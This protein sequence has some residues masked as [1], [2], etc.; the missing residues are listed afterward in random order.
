MLLTDMPYGCTDCEWDVPVDLVAYWPLAKATTKN[1]AAHCHFCQ[2][3]FAARLWQSN[4]KEFRYDLVYQKLNNAK[5]IEFNGNIIP[6]AA[7]ACSQFSVDM[8]PNTMTPEL[9]LKY[10]GIPPREEYKAQE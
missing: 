8:P 2:M 10:L 7:N 3:P 6:Y 9:T 5:E 4:P 1:N